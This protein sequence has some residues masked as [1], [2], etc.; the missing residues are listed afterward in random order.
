M[1]EWRITKKEDIDIDDE[2][3]NVWI[4][5]DENGNIYTQL[6]IEDVMDLLEKNGNIK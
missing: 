5:D 4:D 3:I 6:K 2:H 1:S